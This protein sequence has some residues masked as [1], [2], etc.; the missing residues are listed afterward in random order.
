MHDLTNGKVA[1]CGLHMAELILTGC[2]IPIA[3]VKSD[4]FI[5]FKGFRPALKMAMDELYALRAE[6]TESDLLDLAAHL[7]ARRDLL[8]NLEP[9]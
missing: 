6:P 5:P 2:G 9:R 8:L 4:M 3:T 7:G 1:I